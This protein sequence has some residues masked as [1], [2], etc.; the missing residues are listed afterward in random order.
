MDGRRESR[1]C[2]GRGGDRGSVSA[3]GELDERALR[4]WAA[5]EATALGRGGTAAAARATGI[6]PSTIR[7]GRVEL[8]SGASPGPGRVRRPEAG[9]KRLSETDPTLLADRERLVTESRVVIPSSRCAGRP[10]VCAT[11][12]ASCAPRATRSPPARSRRCCASSATAC[13]RTRRRGRAPAIPIATR[14]FG[15]STRRSRRPSTRASRRSRSTPGRRS[16]SATSRTA[17]VSC[18]RRASRSGA[19]PRLPRP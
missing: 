6:A 12:P 10:R 3:A 4:L 1:L 16:W 9:R 17:A 15:T 14:N 13:R 19:H 5:A 11:S 18:A 8:A 2:G 7:R